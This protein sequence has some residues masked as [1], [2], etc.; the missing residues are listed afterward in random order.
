MLF[1]ADCGKFSVESYEIYLRSSFSKLLQ[2]PIKSLC[3]VTRKL[4]KAKAHLPRP[5]LAGKNMAIGVEFFTSRPHIS[6]EIE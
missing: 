5:D 4:L 3:K 2:R 1:G 6:C